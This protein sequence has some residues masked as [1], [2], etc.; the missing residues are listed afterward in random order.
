MNRGRPTL[1]KSKQYHADMKVMGWKGDLAD[2]PDTEQWHDA[3][4]EIENQYR[5]VL[6]QDFDSDAAS[7]Q[8]YLHRVALLGTLPR[9]PVQHWAEESLYEGMEAL[10]ELIDTY[11]LDPEILKDDDG[12]YRRSMVRFCSELLKAKAALKSGLTAKAWWHLSRVCFYDGQAQ[13]YYQ[14][15]GTAP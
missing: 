13:G 5:H 10:V 14:G 3:A 15:A 4:M 9:L 11:P 6:Q 12:V 8:A 2:D 7:L 1:L